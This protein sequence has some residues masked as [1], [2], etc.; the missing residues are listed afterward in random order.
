MTHSGHWPH[1]NS[2]SA[3]DRCEVLRRASARRPSGEW[4]DD[5]YDVLADCVVI[6]R[7]MKATAVP[8]LS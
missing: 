4:N 8:V 7:I 1:R 2:A 3:A 6:G 5:D